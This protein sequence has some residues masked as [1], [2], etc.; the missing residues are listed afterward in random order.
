MFVMIIILNFALLNEIRW[1][2]TCN[3]DRMISFSFHLVSLN[4]YYIICNLIN[5]H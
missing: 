5:R 3:E 1:K 4:L 2:Q